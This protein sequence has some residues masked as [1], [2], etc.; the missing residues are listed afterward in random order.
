MACMCAFKKSSS[1]DT[2]SGLTRT[3]PRLC[4]ERG[5]T[6]AFSSPPT[7]AECG[8]YVPA[9]ATLAHNQRF[10]IVPAVEGIDVMVSSINRSAP[11]R[12]RPAIPAAAVASAREKV[13]RMLDEIRLPQAEPAMG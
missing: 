1:I 8:F 9:P 13:S 10:K 4:T 2:P 11:A 5:C 12:V 7:S 3:L 6:G